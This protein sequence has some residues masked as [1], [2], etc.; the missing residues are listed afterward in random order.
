MKPLGL[1]IAFGG[2]TLAWFGWASLKGPGVGL[3]DLLVPG[4]Q[5]GWVT[6]A[7]TPGK[8]LGF[9]PTGKSPAITVQTPKGPVA[10]DP[11]QGLPGGVGGLAT[12]N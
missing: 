11:Y 9:G 10:V 4:R 5:V 3:V 2:Y 12:F 1:L 7:G 6:P 8:P